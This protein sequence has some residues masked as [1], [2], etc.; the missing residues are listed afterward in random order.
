MH[1]FSFFKYNCLPY[2]SLQI[3]HD[4]PADDKIRNLIGI[5]HHLW[6]KLLSEN[7]D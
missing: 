1:V 2:H 3:L 6:D 7:R 5:I 4:I